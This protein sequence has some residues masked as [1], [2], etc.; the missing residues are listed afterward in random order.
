MAADVTLEAPAP[1]AETGLIP[2]RLNVEQFLKMIEVGIL[3][4]RARVELIRGRLVKRMTKNTPHGF[5]VDAL[6]RRLRALVEPDHLVREEK[7]VRINPR[8]RPEPDLAVA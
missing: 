1:Q 5:T 4:D 8:S 2:Y 3:S 7:S 6:S